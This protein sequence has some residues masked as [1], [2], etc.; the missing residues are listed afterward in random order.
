MLNLSLGF[1]I[2]MFPDTWVFDRTAKPLEVVDRLPINS[3]ISVPRGKTSGL[4]KIQFGQ[5]PVAVDSQTSNLCT[6]VSSVILSIPTEQL[7][8]ITLA[9]IPSVLRQ[10]PQIIAEREH[11]RLAALNSDVPWDQRRLAKRREWHWVGLEERISYPHGE[12]MD[13]SCLP[14]SIYRTR[15]DEKEAAIRDEKESS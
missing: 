4:S 14:V 2:A 1:M 10:L 9:S 3:T 15:A 6:F 7:R 8:V 12:L 5:R 13:Y 11:R